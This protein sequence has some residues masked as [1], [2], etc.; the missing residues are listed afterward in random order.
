MK[1]GYSIRMDDEMIA[2]IDQAAAILSAR[3]DGVSVKATEAARV[4]LRRGLDAI[5]GED[6]EKKARVRA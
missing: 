1:K 3:G 6:S 4:A 5:I 2:R